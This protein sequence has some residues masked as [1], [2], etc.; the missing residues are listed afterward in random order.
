MQPAGLEIEN[1]SVLIFQKIITDQT[2]GF[3]ATLEFPFR[4]FQESIVSVPGSRFLNWPGRAAQQ[5]VLH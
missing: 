5:S 1:Q 4:V 2:E 3:H